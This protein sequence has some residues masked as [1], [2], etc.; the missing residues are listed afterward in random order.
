MRAE[1]M[2]RNVYVTARNKRSLSLL[3][4]H[5]CIT[6]LRQ[7]DGQWAKFST[8]ETPAPARSPSSKVL[9]T[10]G[11][12]STGTANSS[13]TFGRQCTVR[14]KGSEGAGSVEG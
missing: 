11:L 6:D 9:C 1:Y 4:R 5:L 7:Q 3:K 2:S 13:A 10:R 8:S 14:G 12:Y